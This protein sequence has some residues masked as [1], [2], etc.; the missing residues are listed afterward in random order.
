[1]LNKGISINRVN[2]LVI[3]DIMLDHYIYGDCN[4]ISPEAP[5]QVVEVK[6]E[7]YTLGGAGNVL[8]NL[9]AFNAEATIISVVGADQNAHVIN[10]HLAKTGIT[11]YGVV[12]DEQ[13]CTTIKSRVLAARHQLVRLD[14]EI[15]EPINDEIVSQMMSLINNDI[16]KYDIVLL[17]D[18]NKG[19]LSINFLKQIFEVCRAAGVKT[20]I[21]PKG[22]DF[23]K[24]KGANIIKPNKKEATIA[25][26]I[27]I[28]D[29]ASIEE[30]CVKLKEITGCDEIV[31]TMSEDGIASYTNGQLTIVPTK[32]LDVV[33]VTGAGDTVLASLGVALASGN[34]LAL[35]CDFANHAAAVVVSKVG[36]STATLAE[37]N[38]K[39]GN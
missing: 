38:E 1:M 34:S 17:S 3:G 4:R 14:R 28:K 8:K 19:V 9:R 21:D 6:R 2:V 36:S 15:I 22:N 16:K 37:I 5:V 31:I 24:Y 20:V 25:S 7:E 30:A 29:Q 12:K 39:F 10:E 11:H 13:R 35:A 33:D 26:G 23:S 32:A 18:Y 27:I